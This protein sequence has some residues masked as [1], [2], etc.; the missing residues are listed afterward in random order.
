[1]SNSNPLEKIE[2]DPETPKRDMGDYIE[3]TLSIL[4]FH[5]KTIIA[6]ILLTVVGIW[7]Y[8]I[9][10]TKKDVVQ[11]NRRPEITRPVEDDVPTANLDFK[12]PANDV[13]TSDAEANPSNPKPD[14]TPSVPE[15]PSTEG[16]KPVDTTD[17]STAEKHPKKRD[18]LLETGSVDELIEASLKISD[19]WGSAI[20]SIG[21]IMCSQRAKISRRLLELE[22]TESQR[23]F[24]LT[25][26]IESISLVDS[27]N[28]ASNMNLP[29]TRDALLEIDKKYSQNPNSTVS[30][31]ANLAMTLAPLYDFINNGEIESL[32][33]FQTQF[34][35]RLGQIARDQGA[36]NRL[37]EV[38]IAMYKKPELPEAR[39]QVILDLMKQMFDLKTPSSQAIAEKFRERYLFDEFDFETLPDL[40]Q[41]NDESTARKVNSFFETL[42][43]NP[44]STDT[45]F[46]VAT[47]IV[48]SYRES[49][50]AEQANVLMRRLDEIVDRIP[51]EE[52]RQTVKAA[53]LQL[54]SQ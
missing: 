5:H 11:T 19:E 32:H 48:R 21:L 27:L 16:S 7:V 39:Q 13:P 34:N 35:Q 6:V 10:I 37:A 29:G 44:D 14:S 36:L 17:D 53:I 25:S 18:T 43:E 52:K 40:V 51:T 24:A 42:A 50:N 2:V 12:P 30:V 26:Y 38:S 46:L 22:L 54:R 45:V 1:M 49:G 4:W 3:L 20:P 15:K 33:Q 31:Q 23:I 47:Q 9:S 8:R 41:F 28:V